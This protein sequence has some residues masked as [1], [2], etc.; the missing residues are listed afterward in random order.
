MPTLVCNTYTV[1]NHQHVEK[2][3][4]WKKKQID[5]FFKEKEKENSFVEK[6]TN[7]QQQ[8]LYELI[9][10]VLQTINPLYDNNDHNDAHTSEL[11]P[12]S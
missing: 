11:P 4:D 3:L 7:G 8:N 1:C 12:T 2:I 5:F 10:Y 9:M 6:N